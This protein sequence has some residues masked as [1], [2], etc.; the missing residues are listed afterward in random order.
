MAAPTAIDIYRFLLIYST[1]NLTPLSEAT[2]VALL[3]Q[4]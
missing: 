4:A 2:L 1:V 3:S